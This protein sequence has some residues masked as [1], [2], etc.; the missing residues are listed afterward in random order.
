MPKP[1][2]SSAGIKY[3]RR[4][5]SSA[6]RCSTISMVR[7][8]KQAIA[9]CCATVD[10]EMKRFC[11]SFSISRTYAGGATSQPMRQPVIWKYL[12]KLLMTKMS[13]PASNAV[14]ACLPRVG[15]DPISS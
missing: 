6:R 13:S 3:L 4:A 10:G 12:E 7:G 8:S 14:R 2:D 9:A 11:A 5:S 1:R 15:G